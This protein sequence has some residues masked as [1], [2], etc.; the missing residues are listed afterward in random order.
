MT[1]TRNLT[2]LEENVNSAGVLSVSSGGTGLAV[3]G[4]A[5]NVLTSAASGVAYSVRS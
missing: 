2:L 4:T 1:V 5:G 3:P